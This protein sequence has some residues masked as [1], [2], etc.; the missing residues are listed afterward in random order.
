MMD[1]AAQTAAC[2]RRIEAGSRNKGMAAEQRGGSIHVRGRLILERVLR[3]QRNAQD[4]IL[5]VAD[6]TSA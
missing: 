4:Q 6:A 2:P 5:S 3:G 1:N